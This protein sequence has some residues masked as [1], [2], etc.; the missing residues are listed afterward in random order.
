[1]LNP[2]TADDRYSLMTCHAA[3]APAYHIYGDGTIDYILAESMEPSEDGLSYTMKLKKGL[4]WS[5]GE[6]LTA[7]DIVF[8]YDKINATTQNLFVDDKPIELE[9]VDDT[10]VLFK[11]PSVSASAM[12]MLSDEVSIIP[13]HI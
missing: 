5:D 6:A 8:T 11:L 7:D 2:L 12:E 1:M 3:Y 13:K 4:K 9:K 10:T